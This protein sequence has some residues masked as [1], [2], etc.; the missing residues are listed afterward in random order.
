MIKIIIMIIIM[1]IMMIRMIIMIIMVTITYP[2]HNQNYNNN[3]DSQPDYQRVNPIMNLSAW[4]STRFAAK[5]SE[6]VSRCLGDGAS[7][8]TQYSIKGFISSFPLP[9][10]LF[11]PSSED[12]YNL[13]LY[14]PSNN[15]DFLL[16]SAF[17]SSLSK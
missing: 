10:F 9:I 17:F 2:N 16:I 11:L 7:L 3:D 5:C 14:S 12:R 1:I 13:N 4:L 6:L 8:R 15:F